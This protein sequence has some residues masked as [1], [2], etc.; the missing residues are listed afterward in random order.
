LDLDRDRPQALEYCAVGHS[1]ALIR[2]NAALLPKSI[3][4]TGNS[5]CA[6]FDIALPGFL[7]YRDLAPA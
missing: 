4:P 6:G 5:Y 2:I 1:P 7:F 3:N